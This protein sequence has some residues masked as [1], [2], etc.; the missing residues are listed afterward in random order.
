M[1]PASMWQCHTSGRYTWLAR[2]A[3]DGPVGWNMSQCSVSVRK[4]VQ[5]G[6]DRM[7]A[8]IE[9]AFYKHGVRVARHPWLAIIISV[10]VTLFS[11]VGLVRFQM[12]VNYVDTWVPS[13]AVSHVCDVDVVEHLNSSLKPW[14][15]FALPAQMFA[16][17]YLQDSK[18][19]SDW[20]AG[21]FPPEQR[22][23]TLIVT[24]DNILTPGGIQAL[25]SIHK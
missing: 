3:D 16:Q 10:I 23:H 21:H 13:Y 2:Q 15:V 25:H 17:L 11:L 20:L 24:A 14:F 18:V 1:G 19:S 12:I 7:M 4:M 8:F 6:R 9:A 5:Q 22:S